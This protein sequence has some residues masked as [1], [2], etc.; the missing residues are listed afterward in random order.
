[1]LLSWNS[2]SQLKEHSLCPLRGVFLPGSHLGVSAP[3]WCLSC[4][5]WDLRVL[6]GR[7]PPSLALG[8][9]ILIELILLL[10]SFLGSV[11]NY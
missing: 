4:S 11:T 10:H 5:V 2:D 6:V 9:C 7:E 8:V 1:M 3:C